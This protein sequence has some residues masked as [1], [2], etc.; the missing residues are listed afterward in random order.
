MGEVTLKAIKLATY[1]KWRYEECNPEV[2]FGTSASSVL[3][4]I[5]E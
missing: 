5:E 4:G 1:F 3:K 2:G